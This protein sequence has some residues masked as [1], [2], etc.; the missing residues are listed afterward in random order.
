MSKKKLSP[1]ECLS[2]LAEEFGLDNQVTIAKFLDLTQGR[3]SQIKKSKNL[4]KKNLRSLLKGTFRAG[5][6]KGHGDINTK[7]LHSFGKLQSLSTQQKLAAELKVTQGAVAQWMNGHFQISAE[8]I[9][10]ILK[11]AAKL[12]VRK[13]VELQKVDPGKP[14]GK[15]YFY[16]DKTNAKRT[17]LLKKIGPTR[18]VYLYFDGAGCVTYVGKAD[19]TTLDKEVEN[20][21]QQKT[22]KGR[23]PYGENLKKDLVFE[24]GEIV[25]YI[26]VYDIYP[27]EAISLVEA[28]L[29]RATANVQYNK[30]LE[31]LS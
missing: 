7:I 13:I 8:A 22:K 21:L 28:L 1:E 6:K 9:E 18:G 10:S 29:I 19:K 16:D 26:S 3:I 14:G 2:I 12:S 4:T 20:R 30:K 23:I 15:W 27:R 11:T 31:K 5:R 24:Q 25:K 17:S